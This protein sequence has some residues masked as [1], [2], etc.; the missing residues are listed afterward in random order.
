M[1]DSEESRGG[2]RSGGRRV[3]ATGE[4]RGWIAPRLSSRARAGAGAGAQVQ[5]RRLLLLSA[6]RC[7]PGLRDGTGARRGWCAEEA[8]GGGLVV[9]WST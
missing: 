8:R 2:Q 6:R 7:A 3:T 5:A 9:D 4:V 1:D